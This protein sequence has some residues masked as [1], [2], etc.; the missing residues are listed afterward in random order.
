MKKLED[1]A[2]YRNLPA[3]SKDLTESIEE[4][5]RNNF[6]ELILLIEDHSRKPK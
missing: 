4:K 2:L 6:D 1:L 5:I 3:H